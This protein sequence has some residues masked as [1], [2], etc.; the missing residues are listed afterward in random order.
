MP[1]PLSSS[2]HSGT[3]RRGHACVEL[4]R[5]SASAL[6]NPSASSLRRCPQRGLACGTGCAP[7][8]SKRIRSPAISGGTTN[9]YYCFSCKMLCF[10]VSDLPRRACWALE[11]G[12]Y[13][14]LDT[15][16]RQG[17]LLSVCFLDREQIWV[18]FVPIYQPWANPLVSNSCAF[19]E[20][21]V[22]PAVIDDS[23]LW[24][25]RI[26]HSYRRANSSH[27]SCCPLRSP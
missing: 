17:R 3:R 6:L 9:S 8:V 1:S 20:K 7:R 11:C 22:V 21:Y 18:Q 16:I 13:C 26:K 14:G 12:H 19:E 4:R 24:N 23:D 10:I 25:C 27:R 2:S 5:L 15:R